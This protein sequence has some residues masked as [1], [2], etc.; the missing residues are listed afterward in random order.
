MKILGLILSIAFTLGTGTINARAYGGWRGGYGGWHGGYWH[1]GGWYGGGCSFWPSFT[2]GLG[3]G[4]LAAYPWYRYRTCN[5]VYYSPASS[6]VY[7]QPAYTCSPPANPAPPAA[8]LRQAPKAPE[9]PVWIPSSQGAGQWVPES[10]PYRYS[11]APKPSG[12]SPVPAA[13]PEAVTIAKSPGG[14]PVYI[15]R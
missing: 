7:R 13:P 9:N 4:A 8:V 3:L 15:N 10:N 6:Y 2:F 11:P 14:V 1:G 5:Y 12:A